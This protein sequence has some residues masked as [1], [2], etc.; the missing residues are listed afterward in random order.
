[1]LISIGKQALDLMLAQ[2]IW[3]YGMV[4]G[5]PSTPTIA[6]WI[7]LIAL[8]S[9]SNT[10]SVSAS[11]PRISALSPIQFHRSSQLTQCHGRRNGENSIAI[12]PLVQ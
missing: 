7:M 8:T 5:N 6:D 10:V 11:A 9:N 3:N 12:I 2:P 4:E 1:M